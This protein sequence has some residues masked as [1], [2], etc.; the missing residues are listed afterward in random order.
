[1][2]A[3]PPSDSSF[4]AQA[5]TELERLEALIAAMQARL[6]GLQHDVAEAESRLGGAQA[7]QLVEA[8]EQLV[9]SALRLQEEAD[10][11]AVA[12]AAASLSAQTDELTG[13]SSRAVLLDRLALTLVAAKWRGTRVALLFLDLNNFKQINDSLGH[14]F[15]DLA[16]KL[17]AQR[18]TAAVREIDTVSRFGGDEF[19][20]LLPDLAQPADAGTVADKLIAALA[21]PS[22]V[23]DHFLRLTASI[24]IGVYPD[25][26][27]D[28][29]ALLERA[30]A[31]M[32][33]ARRHG[34]GSVVRH[35][36]SAAADGHL[37]PPALAAF[38]RVATP[39][40]DALAEHERRNGELR[41]ANEQLVLAAL[42]AQ[43]LH[44][45][46]QAAHERQTKF[47][48]QV[49]HELRSPLAPISDAVMAIGLLHAGEP[50]LVRM[51]GILQRQ[52]VHMSRLIGDLVDLSRAQTGKLRID[53]SKIDLV[54]VVD[55]AIEVSRPAMDIRLQTFIVRVPSRPLQLQGDPVR[56]CQV[57]SNLLGNASKYTPEGGEIRL[58]VEAPA[59]SVVLTVSDN[60]IGI[61]AD[62]MPDLFK[63]FVQDPRAID[64]DGSGL[65]LGL[66]VVRE[67][68]EAHGGSV[69]ARSAG[70]GLG[71]QFIVTLPTAIP[72][73]TA[74]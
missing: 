60:G 43:A 51:H 5:A 68:V 31:A 19:V 73:H 21:V 49:A 50:R 47:L 70:S 46:A 29:E 23:D 7:A 71:S 13:L 42:G 39:V 65:G 2:S 40:E 14:A 15:G 8:N 22:R 58:V 28:A 72:S 10:T 59:G 12:L 63:P 11:Q 17:V 26:G 18:L 62:L 44:A 38:Q 37:N 66:T 64:L 36:A 27:D 30:D 9:L 56:L 20:I 67:L 1:M 32:H 41:E 74:P 54:D 6:S 45:A 53:S 48:A 34:L 61:A 16:L 4:A 52:I 3:P 57:L 33:S 35:G 24:G 69:V 25:D 55:A